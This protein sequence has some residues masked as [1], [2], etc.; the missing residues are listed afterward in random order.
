M[1]KL[2][3][4][5]TVMELVRKQAST[6]DSAKFVH[7]QDVTF[8]IG[9]AYDSA[10]MNFFQTPD[11]MKDYDLDYF[12]KSFEAPVK[13]DSAGRLYVDLTAQPLPIIKGQG[14][15]SIRPK[16][17]DVQIVRIS[18]NEW[19][20]LRQLEAF[21]CSPWPFAYISSY[22]KKIIIQ[23]NRPEYK[24]MD[25]IVVKVIPKFSSLDDDDEISTPVGDYNIATMV[26]NIMGIRPTDNSNDDGK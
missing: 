19:M 5:F 1:T 25:S 7:P 14:I 18:E 3:L 2:E 12:T 22:E 9:L 21:S 8:Q 4:I 26:L 17:S 10:V 11:I 6:D 15:K 13:E 20:N 23:A 16:D 24:L